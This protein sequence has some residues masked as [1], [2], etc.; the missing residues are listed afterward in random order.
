MVDSLASQIA[1]SRVLVPPGAPRRDRPGS[2]AS[3]LRQLAK[4]IA[5]ARTLSLFEELAARGKTSRG[6]CRRRRHPAPTTSQMVTPKGEVRRGSTSRQTNKQRH[7]AT[8]APLRRD[9][10][11]D[12]AHQPAENFEVNFFDSLETIAVFLPLA[13]ASAKTSRRS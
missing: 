1:G 10:E 5:A 11:S 13:E 7:Q 4:V 6:D 2:R 12:F 9:G 8:R 3:G